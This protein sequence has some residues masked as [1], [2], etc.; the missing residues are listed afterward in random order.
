M[1]SAN[2]Q[3]HT[4]GSS[5]VP[6]IA[7]RHGADAKST[8]VLAASFFCSP[9]E[10]LLLATMDRP[11]DLDRGEELLAA[12]LRLE[13][14]SQERGQVPFEEMVSGTNFVIQAAV[15]E[16][17][18][19]GAGRHGGANSVLAE[20]VVDVAHRPSFG[21]LHHAPHRAEHGRQSAASPMVSLMFT[22]EESTLGVPLQ[23]N[24]VAPMHLHEVVEGRL[25][26]LGQETRDHRVLLR[27]SEPGPPAQC[28]RPP[29]G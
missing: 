19:L 16:G 27:R 26:G 14:Q 10:L 21:L 28:R 1:A 11:R 23:C 22:L 9:R 6:V 17:L 25:L 24:E 3:R 7:R 29:R 2:S 20:V 4:S 13:G 8:G 18:E 5:P 15:P 12:R